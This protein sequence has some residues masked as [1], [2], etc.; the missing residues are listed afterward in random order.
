M[1][2]NYYLERAD[3]QLEWTCSHLGDKS[4]VMSAVVFLARIN[5]RGRADLV[6]KW[7]HPMD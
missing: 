5:S 3:N 4:L 2:I 6:Y 1:L 7:Y